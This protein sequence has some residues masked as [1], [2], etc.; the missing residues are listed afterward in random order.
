L[1]MDFVGDKKVWDINNEYLFGKSFLV[2]PV[3]EPAAKTQ[4]LY[5][6]EGAGW[7]DFW[8]GE[9]LPGGHEITRE[10]PIDIMPLYVKAGA[11]VPMGPLLQYAAEK[12]PTE[13]EIR[14]YTGADGAFTLYEDENDNYNYEK[15]VFATISL[16][17]ND[18]SKELTI[19]DRKGSFPGML[20]NRVFNI[21]LVSKGN[22]TGVGA[23]S[24][25]KAV[26]YTGKAVSVKM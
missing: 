22:G 23:A 6:P 5:L 9:K 18:Q 16:Q 17:W 21:V 26:K 14:I 19:G 4:T 3:T 24:K 10:T 1:A 13:L 12:K 20:Q 15:G 7:T 25:F 8:T 2:C 11:I